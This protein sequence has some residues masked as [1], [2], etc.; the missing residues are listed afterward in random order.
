[1]RLDYL[2]FGELFCGAGGLSLGAI[3]AQSTNEA[4]TLKIKHAWANDYDETS[5]Q[6]YRLNLCKNLENQA[7]ICKDV[8]ELDLSTL[9]AVDIF[10]Y[11][12]PCNDF[13]VVGEQKG[14]QGEFGSLYQYGVKVL[15]LYKPLAF[16]AENVEGI[17]SSNGG[18]AFQRILRDLAKAGNGYNLTV[19]L[20]KAEDY[21]VPQ[22]R[23][24]Q[25]IVGIANKLNLKFRVPKPKYKDKFV[26]VKQALQAIPTWSKNNEMPK[27]SNTVAER[28]SYIKP[29]Q[30][31]WNAD[32]PEHLKLNVKTAK[33]SQIYKRLHPDKPAYTITA[34]GGGGTHGYHYEEIRPLTNR[35]RARLQTFPDDFEFV[36]NYNQVRRQ[37]GMAVPPLLAQTIFKA[38]L[39]TLNG[40]SYDSIE[41]N[42]QISYEATVTVHGKLSRLSVAKRLK[43]SQ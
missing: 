19:H 40:V 1:M 41:E 27:F 38:L 30:N 28:L 33:L 32:L 39:D 9:D 26:P 23:H 31:A 3:Q 13:S 15:D 29:G 4:N 37:I 18:M 5:C 16:V 43:C 14:F 34:S 21:G 2:K 12:F 36:G 6:T 7:V 11:G 10:A 17:S 8:R 24:R 42:Y 35:E 20:Y 25:I 22:T